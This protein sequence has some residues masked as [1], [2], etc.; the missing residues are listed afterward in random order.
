MRPHAGHCGLAE[1]SIG[2]RSDELG[3]FVLTGMGF[4]GPAPNGT[5]TESRTTEIQIHLD[6]IFEDI[7][8][9]S[10]LKKVWQIEDHPNHFS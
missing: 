7:L 9:Y 8:V 6:S 1:P 10:K 5:R 3:T 4:T 2:R